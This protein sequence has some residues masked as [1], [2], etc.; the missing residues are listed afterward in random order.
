MQEKPPFCS[1]VTLNYNGKEHLEE[2]L[3]SLFKMSYPKDR[4]EVIMV[5]NASTDGSADYV[6]E[7]FP[8]V[9]VLKFDK[10]YGNAEGANKGVEAAKG[11]CI[12]ILDNDTR[13]HPDWLSELVKTAMKDEKTGICGSKVLE[14]RNPDR[15]QFAG[16]Y[17]DMV[18]SPFHRGAGEVDKGQYDREEEIF[19]AMGCALLI[20]RQVLNKLKYLFDPT[21]FAYYEE[22]DLCWRIKY[23]GYR[24]MFSPKSVLWHKGGATSSKMG[25]LM[26][27]YMYRNKIW[28]YKKNLSPPLRQ[29]ILLLVSTR[30]FF[31]ILYRMAGG[32]WEYGFKAFRY[33]FD[34]KESDV[35]ITTVSQR[36]QLRMLS[37]PILAKY[38]QY[39]SEKKRFSSQK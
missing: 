36:K 32:K 13:V 4:Y 35:D 27:F 6:K 11:E 21:Y 33:L 10:N 24:V 19:Y 38:T 31:T 15:I 39:I 37:F 8:E 3:S 28:T 12:I 14:F 7:N 17:L 22:T 30:M 34:K 23:L 26:V 18:G 20:K 9:K 16:G 29:F 2:C 5:D 1:I 25:N